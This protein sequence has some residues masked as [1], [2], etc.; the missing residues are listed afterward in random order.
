MSMPSIVTI[1]RSAFR[2]TCFLITTAS[3]A[4]FARA[5]RTKSSFRV[6]ITLARVIRT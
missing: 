2:S 1:G 6:S 3:A 5:V 4:P